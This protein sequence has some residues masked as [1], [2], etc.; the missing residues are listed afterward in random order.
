MRHGHGAA[1]LAPDGGCLFPAI[2]RLDRNQRSSLFQ[3]ALVA[4]G[5]LLGQ[6][7]ADERAE[8]AAR[9]GASSR[10]T[11][12]PGKQPTRDHRT[13]AWNDAN[14]HGAGQRAQRPACHS[15]ACG[16]A[17]RLFF[18]VVTCRRGFADVPFGSDNDYLTLAKTSSP[19]FV[20]RPRT[21]PY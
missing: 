10:S 1:V 19:M 20:P 13:D 8:V 21:P 12:K 5:F 16:A 6:A 4:G 2:F 11:K 15:T 17:G 9:R 3:L 18:D 7:Q 14:G